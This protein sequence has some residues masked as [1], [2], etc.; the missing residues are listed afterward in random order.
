MSGIEVIVVI[1]LVF[2]AFCLGLLISMGKDTATQKLLTSQMYSALTALT[3]RI[4]EQ[5]TYLQ[6]IGN[7][8]TEFTSLLDD[9]VFQINGRNNAGMLYRTMDGKYAAQSLEELIGKIKRD[10]VEES[11]LSEEEINGL[12]KLFEEDGDEDDNNDHNFNNGK[13]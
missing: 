9:M 4:G 3:A 5:S 7:T 11:Y 12:R 2:N 13:F 10:G 8:L 6:K 1:S